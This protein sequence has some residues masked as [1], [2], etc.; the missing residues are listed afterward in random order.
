M[1]HWT[2]SPRYDKAWK[3]SPTTLYGA[4]ETILLL[5]HRL[6]AS[7]E[8]TSK[9]RIAD[10][11][12]GFTLKFTSYEQHKASNDEVYSPPFYT[13]RG[14][15]KMCLEVDANGYSRGRGTHISIYLYL[16]RG[17]NDDRL[18][19]PFSGNI[20][21]ELLNQLEDKNHHSKTVSL[22]NNACQRV[23]KDG[24]AS[25]GDGFP[26]YLPH[27]CLVGDKK[28]QYLQHNCLYFRV[29]VDTPHAHTQPWLGNGTF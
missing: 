29:K 7:E 19:W 9:L 6:T 16:M 25:M 15:Y 18:P 2:S 12:T 27:N 28:C 21:V 10:Q 24:K 13:S 11:L 14:G 3:W 22:S 20:T 26:C 1:L 17:E 8:L 5:K 23:K 4:I